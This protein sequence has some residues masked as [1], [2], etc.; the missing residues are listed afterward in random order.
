[1]SEQ[2]KIMAKKIAELPQALRER[3]LDQITGASLAL[4]MAQK[5][6]AEA[7]AELRLPN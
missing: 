7:N 5:D 2:E 4:E 1:M 6:A 3:F